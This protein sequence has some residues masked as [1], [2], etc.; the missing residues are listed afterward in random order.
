MPQQIPDNDITFVYV[1]ELSE[2]IRAVNH[3]MQTFTGELHQHA[4]TIHQ[5]KEQMG[6]LKSNVERLMMVT[7]DGHAGKPGLTNRIDEAERDLRDLKR[8]KEEDRR[9]A[10][11]EQGHG[12]SFQAAIWVAIFT[13]FLSLAGQVFTWVTTKT[14]PATTA[15]TVAPGATK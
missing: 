9:R 8:E 7:Y 3:I 4:L 1:K 11:V 14:P 5:L 15:P 6:T 2:S 12:K 13:A 10:D